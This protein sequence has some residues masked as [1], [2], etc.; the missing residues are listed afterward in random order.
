MRACVFVRSPEL[1]T[2]ING[3]NNLEIVQKDFRRRGREGRARILYT[4]LEDGE[5]TV[6][7]S[8][9]SD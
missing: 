9:R 8:W 7:G 6:K 3:L 2:H 4:A 5:I 1:R